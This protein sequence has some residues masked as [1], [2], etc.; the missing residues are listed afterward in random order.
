MPVQQAPAWAQEPAK[1]LAEAQAEDQVQ[2]QPRV[3]EEEPE[4]PQ[5]LDQVLAEAQAGELGTQ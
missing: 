4:Q 2:E 3:L 5:V 1:V